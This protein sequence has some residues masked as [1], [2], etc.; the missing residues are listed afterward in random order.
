MILTFH[1]QNPKHW[2]DGGIMSQGVS[3]VLA[4]F[5]LKLII[6][7]HQNFQIKVQAVSRK[8]LTIKGAD[9]KLQLLEFGVCCLQ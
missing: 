4:C 1:A 9:G 6:S 8:R 2:I 3:E 7:F 5:E